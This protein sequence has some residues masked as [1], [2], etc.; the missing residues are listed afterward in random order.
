MSG[1][2]ARECALDGCAKT[3]AVERGRPDKRFCC[4]AHRKFARRQRL[5]ETLAD[6]LDAAAARRSARELV[7][8][9]ARQQTGPSPT[10]AGALPPATTPHKRL[11]R[12][13]A[14]NL[15]ML[16]LRR[17]L[18][19]MPPP[20]HVYTGA[21]TRVT[22]SPV[23]WLLAPF[24]WI[25]DLVVIVLYLDRA[26]LA[27]VLRAV[28]PSRSRTSPTPAQPAPT[29]ATPPP[30][31]PPLVP[32]ARVP[33]QDRTPDVD[34]A[35]QP[36]PAAV[37]P[38]AP[39][40]PE[41]LEAPETAPVTPA[42]IP[43]RL[44][45]TPWVPEMSPTEAPAP[46][47]PRPPA[48][49]PAPP[50]TSTRPPSTPIPPTSP[51][52]PTSPVPVPVRTA[53]A[54]APVPERAVAVAPPSRGSWAWATQWARTSTPMPET[55]RS[56]LDSLAASK[57]RSALT[58]VGIVIGVAAV[59]MLVGI[60]NGMQADFDRQFSLLANQITVTK[61]KT[62]GGGAFASRNLTDHDVQLMRDPRMA[63]D[64]QSV[65]PSVNGDAMLTV[66]QAQVRAKMFGVT[67]NYLE[68]LDRQVTLG[69]W[70]SAKEVD[71]GER[72]AVLG[73]D[74]VSALWGSGVPPDQV[75]GAVVRVE[76]TNFKVAG[77]LKSDGQNDN[78]VMVP[79]ESARNFLVGDNAGK[80]DQIVVKSTSVT[81]VGKAS[82]EIVD[83]LDQSHRVRKPAARDYNVLTYA[84]LLKK[85]Q[86]FITFLSLFIV[87]IAAVSLLVGGIGVANIMLVAVTERTREIGIRKAIGAKRSTV[88]AQFL[89]EAVLLTSTGGLIGVGI[90]LGG[91]LG[92]K[93]V[94]P[95][96]VDDFPPPILTAPP[97]VVAFA[98]SA[99]IGVVAGSYPAYR[100]ARMRP[101]DALRFE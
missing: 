46:A 59:I 50:S 51:V 88:L 56:A 39:E 77:V 40:T 48:A 64:V 67:E 53:P 54:P 13:P 100:A 82:S 74:T 43:P 24:R 78:V 91:A 92:S 9:G 42:P 6:E 29:T 80:V 26:A 76:H 45:T 61:A 55:L 69:R 68:L 60:G 85:S 41:T 35:A 89:T 44:P 52:L 36:P 19:R 30:L 70:L 65:S 75:V 47:P 58:M 10:T 96:L 2:E 37:A 71:K 62:S 98:I 66:G 17:R 20:P 99:V 22:V 32:P 15:R 8:V 83:V 97:V 27:L 34:H 86:Q 18:R 5:E 12:E 3:F 101:I 33:D 11:V 63:P 7:T 79:F 49:A 28:R 95:K 94:L 81:T 84:S 25:G 31:V 93:Q 38:R 73:E 16:L 87:A 1:S 14:P 21:P 23:R 72:V 90:G 57:L 4:S